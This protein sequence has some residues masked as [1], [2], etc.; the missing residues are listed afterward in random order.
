MSLDGRT[1]VGHLALDTPILTGDLVLMRSSAMTLLGQVL[2]KRAEGGAVVVEGELLAGVDDG[3]QLRPLMPKPF[4]DASLEAANADLLAAYQRSVQADLPV[5]SARV[6]GQEIPAMLRSKGFS[7]HTFLCG[8]SG[9]GKTYALGVILERLLLQTGLRMVIVDPNGDYARIGEQRRD[10]DERTAA[11]LREVSVRVLR[12]APRGQP[13]SGGVVSAAD[14]L[15]VEFSELSAAAKAAVLKLDPLRDA[16]EYDVLLDY[17][18]R[19]RAGEMVDLTAP[20]EAGAAPAEVSL[21]RRMRNLG[22][23]EWSLWARGRVPMSQF[24]DTRPGAT[25]LDVS[26]FTTAAEQSTAIVALL[27]HLWERREER[28]PTLV[29]IDEAHNI[30]SAEPQ[31]QMQALATERLV[32]IAGEG[33]KYGIWLLLST[34]RPSKIHPNVLSQCDNL[35]LMRMNSPADLAELASVFGF[36]PASMLAMSSFFRQGEMLFAGLFTAVPMVAR[37]AHRYTPEGGSDIPFPIGEFER[38]RTT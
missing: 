29:V 15:C 30:C 7:R 12:A 22:V 33:R 38:G 21:R 24:L 1:F 5:A 13:D 34:Q 23:L 8:Q 37:I 16:D 32:Q 19:L 9:S 35:A 14:P 6:S 20:L 25:V 27:D 26:G 31:D 36:A 17:V 11:Q 28:M 3:S 10:L 18:D 2:D 4:S